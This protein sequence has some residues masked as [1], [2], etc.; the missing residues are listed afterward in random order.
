[1][2]IHQAYDNALQHQQS[3]HDATP[4]ER[5]Q[6]IAEC[7]AAV[8][9]LLVAIPSQRAIDAQLAQAQVLGQQIQAYVADRA[10]GQA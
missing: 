5:Q 1:M 9:L 4:E 6:A 8:D 7:W 10:G 2:T 3:M